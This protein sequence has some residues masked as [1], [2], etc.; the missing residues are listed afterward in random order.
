MPLGPAVQ[1]VGDA[2]PTN[3]LLLLVALDEHGNFQP[4]KCHIIF[5]MHFENCLQIP[6]FASQ[7][8]DLYFPHM[9]AVIL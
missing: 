3:D 5:E 9:Y 7:G 4:F 6:D 8:K 2:S 1:N